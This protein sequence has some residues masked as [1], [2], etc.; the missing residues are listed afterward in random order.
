MKTMSLWVCPSLA[1]TI[2]LSLFGPLAQAS[3]AARATPG[4]WDQAKGKHVLYFTKSAGFEHSVVKRPSPDQLSYSET[5]LT[6]L[7]QKHGFDV[8]CTK[9]G[10]VFTPENLAKYDVIV[11]YTSGD[12]SNTG[13]DKTPA[14][15]AAGK[16]ALLDAVKQGKGFVALHAA[17]DSF[18]AK[19]D[20]P[21]KDET[22]IAHGA[23]VD[24]YI[25]ML[26][27]EFIRHGPQQTAK[28]L[29]V[30]RKFPGCEGLQD[31]FELM[32]E[33]YTSKDFAPDLHVIL[34]LE[35]QGMKGIDYQ[36]PPFPSTWARMHGQGRVFY[37]A[38]GHREDVWSNPLFQNLLLGGLGWA[39]RNV[40][41][42]VTPNLQ[43]VTPGYHEIQPE[44]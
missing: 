35:T 34:A 39:A 21:G 29:V 5:I 40:N 9:D 36:R 3:D 38:L 44:K 41:S 14:M 19:P 10:H 23:K 28:A 25:A 6:D 8:T 17:N 31:S 43:A 7:G 4:G 37:T 15:T 2:I 32:E 30:D 12:L 26:G 18:H 11:F 1:T 27:G 33:W 20:V 24:P 16:D 13:T 22:F 42:D